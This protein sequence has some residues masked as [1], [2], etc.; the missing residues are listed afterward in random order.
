MYYSKDDAAE[1]QRNGHL[2]TLCE[3]HNLLMATDTI[4]GWTHVELIRSGAPLPDHV[5]NALQVSLQKYLDL[6]NDAHL[7]F[8]P[9]VTVRTRG[10]DDRRGDRRHIADMY[11]NLFGPKNWY[12]LCKHGMSINSLAP[13]LRQFV[14]PSVKHPTILFEHYKPDFACVGVDLLNKRVVMEYTGSSFNQG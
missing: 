3:K 1:A 10:I 12:G 5:R 4:Y 9:S 11:T 13:A 2:K 8:R 6:R 7:K 14:M